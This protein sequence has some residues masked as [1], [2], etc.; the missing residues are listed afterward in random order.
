MNTMPNFSSTTS[1]MPYQNPIIPQVPYPST[2]LRSIIPGRSVSSVEEITPGEVPMDGSLS[3]FPKSDGSAIYVKSYMGN[4]TIST[5][6]FIPAPDDYVEN[7][8]DQPKPITNEDILEAI[9]NISTRVDK[10]ESVMQSKNSNPKN[11][12]NKNN[13]QNAKEG[14]EVN[15]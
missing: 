5:K 4:G 11:N 3:V 15:A 8:N 14:A 12:R 10:F 7:K 1:Y 2:N 13:Q 9:K 6:T